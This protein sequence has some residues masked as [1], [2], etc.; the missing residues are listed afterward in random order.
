MLPQYYSLQSFLCLSMSPQ[1]PSSFHVTPGP[2]IF[3]CHPRTHH[4]S[5]SPQDPPSFHVTPGPTI[6]PCHPWIH[7]LSMSSQDPP[8]FHVPPGPTIFPCHP[9]IHYL[10]MSSQDS[11]SFHVIGPTP[12]HA[13]H[14]PPIPNVLS[15]LISIGTNNCLVILGRRQNFKKGVSLI[16][17]ETKGKPHKSRP[18]RQYKANL[19]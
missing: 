18:Q 13:Y 6:F 9:W 16:L 12:H 2:T 14:I 10:S 5:M 19:Q 3:P 15:I 11:P 8:S 17:A 1:E 4:L 7:Y